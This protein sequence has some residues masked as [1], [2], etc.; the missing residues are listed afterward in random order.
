VG[1][2]SPFGFGLKEHDRAEDEVF[3]AGFSAHVEDVL[4]LLDLRS[5]VT[6][7]VV[8]RPWLCDAEHP[9]RTT[10][11]I[12]QRAAIEEIATNRACA[13][14]SKKRGRRALGRSRQ[15][16]H[17]PAG[18]VEQAANDGST[19]VPGRAAHDNPFLAPGSC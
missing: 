8:G 14:L 7:L 5:D 3:N 15:R 12:E 1:H 9:V 11:R 18:T 13:C 4:S 2:A 19:L 10:K 17:V 6:G 16:N